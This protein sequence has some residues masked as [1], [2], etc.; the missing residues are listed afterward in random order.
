MASY[1]I[2][3]DKFEAA[4]NG[5]GLQ[6]SAWQQSRDIPMQMGKLSAV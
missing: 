2:L 3:F 5:A 6:Q 4:Y 1:Y